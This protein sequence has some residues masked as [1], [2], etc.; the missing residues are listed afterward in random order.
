MSYIFWNMLYEYVTNKPLP[1]PMFTQ[2]SLPI[3][4]V[5]RPQ[6]V[7]FSG[8]CCMN[9]SPTS[10]YP[11]QCSPRALSL[12]MASLGHNELHLWNMLHEYVTNKPLPKSMFTQSSL[13]IY[14]V[15]RPQW[16]TFC[17]KCC[18]NMCWIIHHHPHL[19]FQMFTG[20]FFPN[21]TRNC[22]SVIY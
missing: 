15:T 12:Y 8:I 5:T 17:G 1:E 19:S 7:T 10:H 3:Y 4:G 14:G 20:P 2:S 18:M 16:V 9:M 13:P 22:R 21:K 6:W 11:S